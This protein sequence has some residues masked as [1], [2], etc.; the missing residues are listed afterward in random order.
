MKT[1]AT[2]EVWLDSARGQLVLEAE[3]R[4][5]E[6]ALP[7]L[8]GRTL[9]QIGTWGQDLLSA[10]SHW[11]TGVIGAG[12]DA[13]VICDLSA[14]PLA[15]NCVDAILL[16]HGLESAPSAHRLLREVDAALTPRGQLLVL[17]F[18][19]HSWWAWRQR[20]LPWYPA[21]PARQRLLSSGRLQDWLRL[22]DYEVVECER[23][24]PGAPANLGWLKPIAGFF[25]PTYLVHARKRRIPVNP[26]L[27]PVWQ[28]AAANVNGQRMP[29]T[30]QSARVGSGTVVPFSTG[31]DA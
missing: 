11:R 20:L 22:L 15:P 3:R 19:P 4:R 31:A 23:F 16:A 25:A 5:L 14:L 10:A 2:A 21:L 6:T 24:G 7:R 8:F 12:G 9:L 29:S 30:R 27:S 18:N 13:Q 1:R 17:G 26:L 28:R